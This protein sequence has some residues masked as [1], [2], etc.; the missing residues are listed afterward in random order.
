MVSVL[1]TVTR[2]G[3]TGLGVTLV[4]LSL[5]GLPK[6]ARADAAAPSVGTCL[7]ST[8][9]SYRGYR[10]YT[11]RSAAEHG[12]AAPR[13][14]LVSAIGLLFAAAIPCGLGRTADASAHVSFVI[15]TGV[16]AAVSF[17]GLRLT[18]F[19]AADDAAE[20]RTEP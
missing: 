3:L 2:F 19:R 12:R 11:F 15:V 16:V 9:L 8:S 4:Y 20:E 17:A 1:G 18:V 5:A 7:V 10:R 13:F 14:M 6:L